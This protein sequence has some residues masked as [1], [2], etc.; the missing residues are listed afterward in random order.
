MFSVGEPVAVAFGFRTDHLGA[1][2]EY[3]RG[4][5][6]AFDA[7]WFRRYRENRGIGVIAADTNG[8]GF[9]PFR[10]SLLC[11]DGC[12]PARGVFSCQLACIDT[13]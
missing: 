5:L 13:S 11:P 1:V 4:L 3:V 10:V 7:L 12:N 6:V 8:T 9:G 2:T